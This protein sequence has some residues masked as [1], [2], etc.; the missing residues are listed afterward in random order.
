MFE[1]GV[2]QD[3]I[4]SEFGCVQQTVS[5][6]ISNKVYKDYGVKVDEDNS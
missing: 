3:V 4:A 2:T 6:I 1:R 5:R